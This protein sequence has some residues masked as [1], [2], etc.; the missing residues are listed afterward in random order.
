MSLRRENKIVIA[1]EGN[2]SVDG[3]RGRSRYRERKERVS[4]GQKYEWKF[5]AGVGAG[6]E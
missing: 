4:E 2:G 5:A 1:G 6:W 3:Y